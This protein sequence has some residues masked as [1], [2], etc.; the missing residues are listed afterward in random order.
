MSQASYLDFSGVPIQTS[1]TSL[2]NLLTNNPLAQDKLFASFQA[3]NF[4]DATKGYSFIGQLPNTSNGT[5]VTIF[6]SNDASDGSYT[7]AVRGTEPGA[8]IGMDLLQDVLGVVLAGK[9]KVQLIEAFR[10]YKQATTS[11]GQ[12]VAYTEQEKLALANILL[13]G[14]TIT[15]E[16]QNIGAALSVVNTL[17][18]GDKGLG[19]AGETLIPIESKGSA[20]HSFPNQI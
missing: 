8:Q 19:N 7:I 1:G 3:K 17:I 10:Y 16:L 5:S 13:S 15:G 14:T 20:S 4:T 6:K 2:Q 12:N 18:A 11:G 9:A